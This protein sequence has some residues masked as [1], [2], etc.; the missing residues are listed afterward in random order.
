MQ[1][2]ESAGVAQLWLWEDCFAE[3]GLTTAAAALAWTQRLPRWR[4][5]PA[6][7]PAAKPRRRRDGDR[8]GVPDVPGPVRAWHRPR[9]AGV[10]GA[11]GRASLLADHVASRV[12]DGSARP[13]ARSHRRR[14]RPLRAPGQ[15]RPRL[16]G[17]RAA[18]AGDRR[19]W[20]ED[21]A[22]GGRDRRRRHPRLR[23]HILSTRSARAAPGQQ[24]AAPRPAAPTSRSTWSCSSS[25][26]RPLRTSA[27][28]STSRSR[29]SPRS[30]PAR[31]RSRPAVRRPIPSRS[32]R[33]ARQGRA[34]SSFLPTDNMPTDPAGLAELPQ[35]CRGVKAR[36]S[37]LDP[38][39]AGGGDRDGLSRPSW[40]FAEPQSRWAFW[41]WSQRTDEYLAVIRSYPA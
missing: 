38:G 12:R 29:R 32:S 5:R 30:G 33:R 8:H 4:H 28:R 31:S 36:P 11:G 13:A 15:G 2:A 22:P 25:S 17:R 40:I 19:S 7:G 34:V 39:S 35:L 3:G 24:K 1:A 9:R 26:T 20:S 21:R 37:R 10:D 16:A 23:P 41:F 18:T 14:E 6:S 27:P